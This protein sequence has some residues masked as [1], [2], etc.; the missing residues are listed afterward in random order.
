M[1]RSDEQESARKRKPLQASSYLEI[2]AG[3]LVDET[4]QV[5]VSALN[6]ATAP[7]LAAAAAA[8]VSANNNDSSNY[9]HSL[10]GSN[11]NSKVIKPS[12]RRPLPQ[13]PAVTMRPR[14]SLRAS[15]S[16]GSLVALDYSRIGEKWID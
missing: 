8:L 10:N 15:Y 13:E 5:S 3:L 16:H 7:A 2:D 6:N 14:Q 1:S 12:P 4:G 9:P 11:S